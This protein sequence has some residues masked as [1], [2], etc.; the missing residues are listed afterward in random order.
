MKKLLIL[1]LLLLA[2]GGGVYWFYRP[3][4]VLE[5]KFVTSNQVV[6]PSLGPS[7]KPEAEETEGVEVKPA[8][9]YALLSGSRQVYQ[10]F[11]NCGPATLSMV[12]SF[13]GKIV[14][15]EELGQKMRPYQNPEGDNDDKTIFTYEFVDW[16]EVYGMKA[17]YRVNGDLELLKTLTTNGI[18][19]V[20][21]TW[22]HDYD[23]IGHFRL[24]RGF[25]QSKQVIIQDDS[26]QGPNRQISYY[27]FLSLWQPFNYDY[28]I[29]YPEEKEAL[30]KAILGEQMKE[31]IA[32]QKALERAQKEEQLDS[33]NIYPL[34]NQS[35]AYYHLGQYQEST[36]VFEKV[37]SRL[38]RRMLWYQ[39][40]PILAYQ[41]LGNFDRVFQ[42]IDKILN[43]GN[44]AFAELYVIRG[45][46]YQ[47]QNQ[48][49]KA[50]QEFEQALVYQPNLKTA[51]E[52]LDS[53]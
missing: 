18:P 9:D 13:W 34:F 45:E 19:V 49:D 50:K 53:L 30:V 11:N 51:Q 14:S 10:T 26:Y 21:K 36:K 32:W 44:R 29:V 1:A 52:G 22:L 6:S 4:P 3:Q 16:A 28:V 8:G 17:L 20:T 7:V 43:N 41:K 5:E 42:I 46:I 15:Q 23:D 25:D 39:I 38:P 35:V 12:L 40:E 48:L 37:E 2:I 33:E 47:S 31:E 24:V 27:D